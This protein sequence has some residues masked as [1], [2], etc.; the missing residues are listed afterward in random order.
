V[1]LAQATS[2]PEIEAA[3]VQ[4]AKECED[5]IGQPDP[6]KG[7]RCCDKGREKHECCDGKIKEADRKDTFSDPAYNKG[8]PPSLIQKVNGMPRERGAFV[9]QAIGFAKSLGAPAFA[10]IPAFLAGKNFPDVAISNGG[11]PTVGNVKQVYD[12]KFPCPSS[13]KPEWGQNGKQGQNLQALTGSPN[14]PQMISP[15]GV[16]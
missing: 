9:R 16:F 12:F 8:P 6:A 14:A 11:P 7:E 5:E 3:L 4:I 2:V 10:M 15:A 1:A 13:K